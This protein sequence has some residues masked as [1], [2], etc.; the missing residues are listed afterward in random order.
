MYV[1]TE[2]G[3]IVM[4]KIPLTGQTATILAAKAIEYPKHTLT[5]R[6]GFLVMKEEA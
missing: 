4:V 1:S 5:I 6:S 2:P 3:L